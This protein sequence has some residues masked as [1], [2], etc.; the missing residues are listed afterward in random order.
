MSFIQLMMT[1]GGI[2]A[3]AHYIAASSIVSPF[4]HVYPWSDSTGFGAKVTDPGTLP[5]SGRGIAFSPSGKDIISGNSASPFILAY[6]FSSAGFGTKYSNPGTLPVASSGFSSNTFSFSADGNNIAMTTTTTT[7]FIQV[8]PWV[9]GTGFGT[10]YSNPST[11][12]VTGT[13]GVTFSPN[14]NYIAIGSTGTTPYVQAYPW[15][16]GTGFGTKYSNP[17]TLAGGGIYNGKSPSFSPASDTIISS[18]GNSP[19]IYAYPFSSSGWG[20]KYTNPTSLP[21]VTSSNGCIFSNDGSSITV[22]N[23]GA[24][25]GAVTYNWSSGFGTKYTVSAVGAGGSLGPSFQYN[26]TSTVIFAA[27][28]Q[29]PGI[30]A[31]P[32][33][34]GIGFGTKYADPATVIGGQVNQI[35]Y[36]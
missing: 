34:N 29:S 16:N 11:L 32:W 23:G 8:Y 22:S 31:Y 33:T 9:S 2:S 6:P 15:V 35:S 4:I 13:A 28:G 14:N 1:Y 36:I 20:T 18:S 21:S 25:P 12:P 7:P 24:T 30:Y 10:K 17:S 26:S 27:L 5:T 19:F 3:P